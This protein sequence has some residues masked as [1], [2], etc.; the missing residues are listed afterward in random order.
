[1]TAARAVSGGHEVAFADGATVTTDVLVGAD[2]AWSKVRSLLSDA[3]PI[4]SG[5]SFAE[6]RILQADVRHPALAAAVGKGSL[7]ALSDEKGLLA[8]RE[9][10]GELCIYIALKVRADRAKQEIT[11]DGLL[12]N[13][14]DWH[15]DLRGL[16]SHSDGEIVTR[17]RC[18]SGIAG[19][20]SQASRWSAMQ[21]TLCP[22]SQAKES[23]LRCWTALNWRRRPSPIPAISRPPLRLMKHQ[24]LCAARPRSPIHCQS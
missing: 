6:A 24:C 7:F 2:G 3:T 20:A 16:I 4:Y 9:H 22:P 17:L 19:S 13:F 1:V 11:R 15:D 18:R 23:I 5:L 14:A 12:A 10:D 8:H 21:P